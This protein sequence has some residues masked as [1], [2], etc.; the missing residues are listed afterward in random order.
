MTILAGGTVQV[1]SIG[2]D[3]YIWVNQ[4][5]GLWN[6]VP[7]WMDVSTGLAA[8]S[9]PNA[10]N[11][12]TITGG[13]NENF[14][15]IIGTGGAAQLAIANDVL[16]WGTVAVAGAVTLGSAADLDLDGGASLTAGS[17]ALGNGA[18][19]EVG[20]GSALTVSGGA[21][22]T[23]GFLAA[24]DGSA[25]QL[26]GLVANTV[27]IG[28]P[29]ATGL[30][31]VDDDSAIEVGTAGGAAL[32]VI[33]IDTGLTAAA[34]GTIDGN[35][36]VNGVLG[37]QA[38]GSLTI[39][40]G[41]PFG[42]GQAI[43]GTGTLVLSENS[44]LTLGVADSAAVAF[45]G[46][47]GTLIADAP[48]SGTIV[49]FTSGD[50]IE[51]AG[52]G[53]VVATGL[54]YVQTSNTIAT[55]TLTKGGNPVGT[56][57]LAGNYAGDLFHLSLDT[58]GDGLI[59]LQTVG[60]APVQPAVI[61][62][63][64]GYDVLAAT[65]NN[66]TLTGL[67]GGDS[68]GAG[69]FTGIDFKDTSADLNGSAIASFG[70]TD[71]VDLT[72]MN[73]ATVS[74][75]YVP[76]TNAAASLVVTDGTHTATIGISF[77]AGLPAG[78]F[79]TNADG[80]GGTDVRYVGANTDTYAFIGNPGGGYG[81]ASMWQDI[82]TGT[83]ANVPP[84]YGNTVTIAGGPGGYADVT[85]NGFAASLVTT[86]SVLLWDSLNA[87]SK[88][89]GVSGVLTQTGTLALDGQASLVLAGSASVGGLVEIGDG[90]TVTA[91]GGLVFSSNSAGL[92]AIDHG[93]ARFSSV[94]GTNGGTQ[95]D[96]S[97]IAVD[98]TG[99]I[100]FGATGTAA[101]GALT[102]ESG[103]TVDLAGAIDGNVVVNGTLVV[104]GTLAVAA[105]G[106]SAPSV[107]GNG[108][109][110]LTY[111]D[112][113]TLGGPDSTAI[114]F[115]QTAAGSF[116]GNTEIL[117][118]PATMP[119][120]LISGY[121][122]GDV[123]TVALVVTNLTY[124][125][126]GS[127]GRLTLLDGGTAVGVL[128][129][130]GTYT[131]TQFQVQLAANGLSSAIT[132]AVTPGTAG[133]NSV[134]GTADLYTWNNINGGVWGNASNWT[135]VTAGGTPTA[136]P[137]AGNAVTINDTTGAWTPQVIAGPEAAAS[138]TVS[139]AANTILMW[140]IAITGLFS[141]AEFGTVS[142][143]VALYSGANLSAGSLSVA[144]LLRVADASLMTIVGSGTGTFISGELAVGSDSI[145]RVEGGT[146]VIS[147]TV[148]VDGTSSVEFGTAG[149]AKAGTLTIDNGQ[150]PDLQGV[151]VIAANVVVNGSLLVYAGTIE[152]F[153]GTVG[154]ITGTGTITI[155]ALGA[156]G[157]L[158]LDASDT[159]AIDFGVYEVNN[160][161]YAFESLELQSSLRIG[162]IAGFIAGDTIIID[163]DVTGA[164][165]TQTNGTQGTL[166][167]TDGA[168]VVGTLTFAGNY[169]GSL[170]QL[171]VAPETGVATIS[172][173]TAT[174]STGS[175][176]ASTNGDAYDWIGASGGSWTT[177]ANWEDVTTGTQ[178]A[179]VA[180]AGNVVLVAGSIGVGQYTTIGGNGSAVDFTVTGN[181]MLTGQLN[182]A[183]S[184][185]VSTGS[186]PAAALTLQAGARLTAGG[187]AQIFGRMEVEDGSSAV[188][189]G[190]ALL[191]GASLLVLDGSTVQAGGLIGDS[192]GDVIAVDADS[193]MKIGTAANTAAGTLTIAAGA[194]AEFSGLIYAS[195][196]DNG[197]FRVSGGGTLL[198]D[199]NTTAEDDPYASS[200]TI[201]GSGLLLLTEGS[202]LG[203]G[204]VDSAAI[205]FVGPDATLML[206][207]I[208]TA[209]ITGF[210]AGDQIQLDQ[211]VT[212]V[213]YTQTTASTATLT[214]TDGASSVGV[215][216]LAG[217]YA[218]NYAFHLDT[219]PNGDTAVI[220][221]QSL[222]IAPGQMT[223]IGGTVGADSLVATANGQ[224]ITGDG[225]GDVLSGGV[226]TGIDFKDYSVYL[227]GSAIQDF[228]TSDMVDFIDMNPATASE[229]Y[230]NGILS[231]SDGTHAAT[232]S[233]AF[234]STPATGSFHIASDGAS[235]TK[236]TWS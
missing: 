226:Y 117:A 20:G 87:G 162:T 2:P 110:E 179:T 44:V 100:A 14:T 212:G 67:G 21:A 125:Q 31:A 207:A 161:P 213:T 82:T 166:T 168:T 154:A 184:V 65:A 113:L 102:I 99:S 185:H 90:S 76:G 172:L 104:A 72:D 83:I 187:S 142:P 18:S 219:A 59:T 235:G 17:L 191:Y 71:L 118:L 134:S 26:G 116:S 7:N 92:L 126:V 186:G 147:G 201:S 43:G 98:P 153:G 156:S 69:S 55:L 78:F 68:L 114:L 160:V 225:G 141:V 94:L 16:L 181:V 39:D 192:A 23:S 208:P 74:V 56:L 231:I 135:D 137:G 70:T 13:T 144:S 146:S 5:G 183:G 75:T 124:N 148:A 123:I 61:I 51:I 177:A 30:I 150:A 222:L 196:V 28:Y 163:Q 15:A 158:V 97:V 136:A 115:S 220:T 10:S 32:G 46:P 3:A 199:M 180:G 210:T 54:T 215:L 6:A 12:V 128:A 230:S 140:N 89:A 205:Q 151:A 63:T 108:T 204:V 11:A 176:A 171:D 105:F 198:I 40:V 200:P 25:I 169:A 206:A 57:R 216:K 190:Y 24:I 107:S 4:Y 80:T 1:L 129:L 173:Q 157:S 22:L 58:A 131:A 211:T 95:F 109:I 60:T 149:T 188:M 64:A 103:T 38:H 42:S 73:P 52:S 35:L 41:D 203:L 36:I 112:T 152:G 195:L 127:V 209:T 132:Y 133:G 101:A 138:L 91:A 159:V 45:G 34:T 33:T 234:A 145:V 77:T 96:T 233:L 122:A 165:F 202:T 228:A 62:G 27:N 29:A 37:V 121:T 120:G 49:G 214:L 66:Q 88:L 193:V 106:A 84:S 232:L 178:P 111:G 47:D 81:T 155:G 79:A 53:T 164:A 19:L 48:P 189:P 85:G 9:V 236:L 50:I 139:G 197:Q 227:S 130:S 229:T 223:L 221:L 86:G 217:S 93:S 143:E 8:S 218:G 170:F 119:T 224:T 175:A 174:N 194:P 167:L 182:V